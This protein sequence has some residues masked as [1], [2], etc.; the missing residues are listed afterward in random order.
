MEERMKKKA[1]FRMAGLGL[2]ILLAWQGFGLSA[3]YHWIPGQDI[4]VLLFHEVN[5]AGEPGRYLSPAKFTAMMDYL[6]DRRFQVLALEDYLEI[7]QGRKR[8][9]RRPVVITFDDGERSVYSVSYPVLKARAFPAA[10][11]LVSGFI[12]RTLY[13]VLEERS[14]W[15]RRPPETRGTI[16][17][18]E[19]IGW[20]EVRRMAEDGISFHAHSKTH[21]PLTALDP[22]FL[23][24]EI[25][26]SKKTIE[27]ETGREVRYFAYPWGEFN[28]TVAARLKKAGYA[29]AFTTEFDSPAGEGN[30]FFALKRY[31]ITPFTKDRDFKIIVWGLMPLKMG[32]SRWLKS[33]R[34]YEPLRAAVR[35]WEGRAH[36]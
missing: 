11:F 7:V 10:V 17:K 6:K 26:A 12:G 30:E 36:E 13:H 2:L 1:F 35:S 21:A 23:A 15:D 29:A 14:Y 32:L 34:M 28:E 4:P 19:M 33:A 9:P 16:W 22:D 8:A 18:F 3:S 5:E 24:E 20:D 25:L 27:E 31:E